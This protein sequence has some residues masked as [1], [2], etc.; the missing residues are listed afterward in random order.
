MFV[1]LS[2]KLQAH[3]CSESPL[4]S[5]LSGAGGLGQALVTRAAGAPL[6]LFCKPCHQFALGGISVCQRHSC[7]SLWAVRPWD[8][9]S[10]AS[11]CVCKSSSRK[12]R[13]C[14]PCAFGSHS[15]LTGVFFG[16]HRHL[17]RGVCLLQPHFLAL[18][19][20]WI[21]LCCVGTCCFNCW[22]HKSAVRVKAAACTRLD[23][24]GCHPS[25]HR[26]GAGFHQGESLSSPVPP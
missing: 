18:F 1:S 7:Y 5:S 8:L 13:L 10:A 26:H 22:P 23:S 21:I 17:G 20:R 6:S 2:E 24:H 12:Y 3:A 19:G 16:L 14:W 4:A 11:F 15:V 25:C 9:A